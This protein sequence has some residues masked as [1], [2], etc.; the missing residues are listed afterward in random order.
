MYYARTYIYNAFIRVFVC[1]CVSDMFVNKSHEKNRHLSKSH[2]SNQHLFNQQY[3]YSLSR[4][5]LMNNK[6]EILQ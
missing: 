4:L 3:Y 1:V 6:W 2:Y 5:E